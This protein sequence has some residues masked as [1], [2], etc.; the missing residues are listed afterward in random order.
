MLDNSKS[1]QSRNRRVVN[2]L[3]VHDAWEWIVRLEFLNDFS[4]L[5][6]LCAGTVIH[7]NFVLTAAH[8][9][10]GKDYVILTF[11]ECEL[12]FFINI[13]SNNFLQKLSTTAESFI[14][15]G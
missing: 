6:N 2:G 8:C 11:K 4:D 14:Y 10:F 5:S 9:C 1:I 12:K 3:I 7:R 13:I 15:K